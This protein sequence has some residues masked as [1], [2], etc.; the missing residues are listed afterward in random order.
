MQ[1]HS[2]QDAAGSISTLVLTVTRG[3]ITAPMSASE[4]MEM[5]VE[6]FKARRGA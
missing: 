6:I 1:S 5:H 3:G 2:A 4:I